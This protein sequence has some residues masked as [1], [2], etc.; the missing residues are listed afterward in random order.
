MDEQT[1]TPEQEDVEAHL[2]KEALAAGTASAAIFAGTG[3]AGLYP[4]PTP[5]GTEAAAAELA[6]IPAKSDRAVQQKKA[7]KKSAKAKKA[8]KGSP[9]GGRAQPE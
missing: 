1:P 9:A 7:T 2:L 3:Q 4:E 5:P 8:A 6:L